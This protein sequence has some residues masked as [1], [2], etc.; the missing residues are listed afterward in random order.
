[1]KSVSMT[2]AA[3]L[4]SK[5]PG[6][7]LFEASY[8]ATDRLELMMAHLGGCDRLLVL[9]PAE[10]EGFSGERVG[11]VLVCPADHQN[12]LVLNRLFSYTRP[13]AMGKNIAT[14]GT[15]DRLSLANYAHVLC[16]ENRNVLPILA[17]Q[18]MRELNLTHRTYEDVLD[19]AV[20]AVMKAG[21]RHGFGADGDHLKTVSQVQ[22]ALDCGYSMI[23]LDCSEALKNVPSDGAALLEAYE[24]LPQEV[25]SA[26]EQQYIGLTEPEMGVFFTQERL[27]AIAVGYYGAILLAERVYFDCVAKAGRPV[28]LEI[29]LDETIS[30]T[31]PEAHYLVARELLNAGVEVTSLAPRFVGE[32]QKG[33]DYIG[34]L[35][36]FRTHLKR[37]TAVANYFGHKLSIHSGSDKFSV[38]PEIGALTGGRVHVKTAG[39]SWLEAVRVIAEKEPVLYREMHRNALAHLEEARAF[40]VVNADRTKIQPLDDVPDDGLAAYLE[41]RDARQLLHITYAFQLDDTELRQR[42]FDALETHRR[43]YERGILR[44]IG[45]HLDGLGLTVKA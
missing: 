17:Q 44:H 29:S 1:M 22:Y 11:E 8:E 4:L 15:G 26:Y 21:W 41:G 5:A 13:C 18:S 25:R 27:M 42:I 2:R 39:T 10:D 31:S 33:I 9:G 45:R 37:H 35:S 38:F 16:M 6:D 43:N 14:F 28:D 24:E 30:V 12:R 23:T 7:E 20:W 34:D 36:S 32:F 19:A 40:Y 3:T